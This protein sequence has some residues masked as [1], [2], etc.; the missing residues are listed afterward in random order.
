MRM[1]HPGAPPAFALAD[2]ARA[3]SAWCLDQRLQYPATTR[4]PKCSSSHKEV[5]AARALKDRC[6]CSGRKYKTIQTNV[7]TGPRG[8][9]D[10]VDEYCAFERFCDP[11]DG[12][13][14]WNRRSDLFRR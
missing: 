11:S 7:W 9:D 2:S 14:A 1:S 5:G 4:Q 12:W 13:R 3:F 6:R 10:N 8:K